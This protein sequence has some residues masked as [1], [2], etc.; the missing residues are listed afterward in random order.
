LSRALHHHG[1]GQLVDIVPNHMGVGES[2]N[3]WWLDVL[4]NGPS[5][6][7]APYFDIDWEPLKPELAGKVLLPILGD[8]FGR[9]LEAGELR[10]GFDSGGFRL[11]YHE[12]QLPVSPKSSTLILR[13]VL[14]RL[15][16]RLPGD[17][18]DLIE[19]E[20]IFTALE[21]LPARDRTDAQS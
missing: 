9:V 4:E 12:H 21:H 19:L 7:Y 2:D 8:Q 10:L 18:P 5:S 11:D 6:Q 3:E 16:D 20:S 13:D 1:M 15:G 14:T 17:H